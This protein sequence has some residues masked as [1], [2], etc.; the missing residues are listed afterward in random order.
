MK[1]TALILLSLLGSASFAGNYDD[2]FKVSGTSLRNDAVWGGG[3]EYI[4]TIGT[5]MEGLV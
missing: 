5:N 2:F 4:I 1:L 3:K